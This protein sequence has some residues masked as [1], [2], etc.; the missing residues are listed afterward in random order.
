M[1][2]NIYNINGE[3]KFRWMKQWGFWRI[4][5]F[6]IIAKYGYVTIIGN[7][8]DNERLSV[9]SDC[10]FPELAD[11]T[12]TPRGRVLNEVIYFYEK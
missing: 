1:K 8:Y 3:F 6:G 2:N 7:D 5:W 4:L 10:P 11:Y 12:A 9:G